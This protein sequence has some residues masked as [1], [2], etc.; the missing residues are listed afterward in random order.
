MSNSLVR[1]HLDNVDIIYGQSNNESFNQETEKIECN[2]ALAITRAINETSQ[3]KLYSEL[4]FESLKFRRS[5]RKLCN[6]EIIS[7]NV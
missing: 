3:N 6:Y 7:K 5:F 4:Y 2:S 1:P